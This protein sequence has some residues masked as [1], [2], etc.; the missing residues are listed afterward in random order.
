MSCSI[1][2]AKVAKQRGKP[3]SGIIV[4][5]IRSPRYEIDLGK[6]EDTLGMPVVAR[7]M[8]DKEAIKALHYGV[9]LPLLNSK[10]IFSKEIDRLGRA[11]TNKDEELSWMKK[12]FRSDLS[13][14]QVNRQVLKK[15][16]YNSH[17]GK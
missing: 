16:F 13:K 1:K 4:N 10:A 12:M 7:I 15:D 6:I 3:I 17:F 11:L 5:K 9:P 2:A 14:E 8:D